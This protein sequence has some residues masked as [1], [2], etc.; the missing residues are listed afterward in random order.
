[1]PLF[2]SVSRAPGNV[3]KE[4]MGTWWGGCVGGGVGVWG[5]EN[6]EQ[7][8]GGGELGCGSCGVG[9][10]KESK[11][12][13]VGGGWWVR[14][15]NYTCRPSRISMCGV[16][17][18]LD[19]RLW[20]TQPTMPAHPPTPTDTQTQPRLRTWL[21]DAWTRPWEMRRSRARGSP[22]TASTVL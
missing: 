8:G 13:M 2:P 11:E 18:T 12:Q 16:W 9:V 4:E 22:S 17:T 19:G 7:M 5:N 3:E 15:Y 6:K 21:T 20:E 10:G 1:M 14:G